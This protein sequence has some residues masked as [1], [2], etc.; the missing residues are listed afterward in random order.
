MHRGTIKRPEH[1]TNNPPHN[2]EDNNGA[3]C[4]SYEPVQTLLDAV[5]LP[6]HAPPYCHKEGA[7]EE[8]FLQIQRLREKRGKGKCPT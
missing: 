1:G 5:G 3:L 6:L 8:Q 2:A 7:Q 4:D